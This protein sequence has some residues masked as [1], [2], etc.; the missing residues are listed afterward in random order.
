MI[1]EPR[2]GDHQKQRLTD[3][4]LQTRLNPKRNQPP[5]W[6]PNYVNC[7]TCGAQLAV[8]NHLDD[9]GRRVVG[10]IPL[11]C[12]DCIENKVRLQDEYTDTR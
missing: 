12:D 1:K 10:E 2:L 5:E 6:L 4:E 3:A 9:N 7:K 8:P 11:Q